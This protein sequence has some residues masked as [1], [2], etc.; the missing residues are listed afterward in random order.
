MN[1]YTMLGLR[2]LNSDNCFNYEDFKSLEPEILLI[3]TDEAAVLWK[4]DKRYENDRKKTHEIQSP[5]GISASFYVV[6]D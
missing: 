6:N 2:N 1:Q 5:K 4:N 3:F